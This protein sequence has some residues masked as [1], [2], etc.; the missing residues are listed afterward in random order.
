MSTAASLPAAT[1]GTELLLQLLVLVSTV[2]F[3][4]I[5]YFGVKWLHT[6]AYA[7]KYNLDNE[8]TERV[9]ENALLWAESFLK[10]QGDNYILKHS[11]SV[12]YFNK[13]APDLV[14]KY[15]D[16]LNDMLARKAQQMI[17]AASTTTLVTPVVAGTAGQI[18]PAQQ[19][20][21]PDVSQPQP[22]VS[23]PVADA[24]VSQQP[25]S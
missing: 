9:L 17:K 7:K 21:T 14:K 24:A 8:R 18:N 22:E 4:A 5:G 15:G 16:A 11:L 6:S 25:Q 23:A 1:G 19:T 2:V 13:V 10:T 3:G 12:T 20:D